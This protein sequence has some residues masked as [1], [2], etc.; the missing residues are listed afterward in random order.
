MKNENKKGICMK[1]YQLRVF[2]PMDIDELEDFYWARQSAAIQLA[3]CFHLRSFVSY[4]EA[5]RMAC[6]YLG[7]PA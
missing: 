4:S 1:V 7:T 5:L 6:E 3:E 2:V